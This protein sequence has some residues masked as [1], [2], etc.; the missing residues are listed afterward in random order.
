MARTLTV[1]DAII[2]LRIP[3]LFNTPVTIQGFM[4]DNVY[5]A[6]TV[7]LTQTAMGVDGRLSAGTVLNPIDQTFY[8][9]ADS[10][11]GDIFDTWWGISRTQVTTLR[12]FGETTLPALGTTYTS[13]NGALISWP[14]IPA[15]AKILQGR[16]ALIRWESIV[17]NPL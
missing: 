13:N 9:Q 11:S 17:P 6:P 15:G 12:C 4:T 5:D 3:G 1:A 2:T 14:P 7:E 16:Q 8:I 10:E